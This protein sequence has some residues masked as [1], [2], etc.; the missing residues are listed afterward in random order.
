MNS[1]PISTPELQT[2]QLLLRPL[3]V[4]D[5]P[6]IQQQFSRWE[7]VRLMS[8]AIPWPY[9]EDGALRFLRDMAL[10]AKTADHEGR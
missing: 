7:V 10:P 9:P 5:A 8:A 4:L 1:D 2:D 6:A 3:S